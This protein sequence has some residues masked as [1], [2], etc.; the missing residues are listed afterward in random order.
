MAIQAIVG[1]VG[2]AI[3]KMIDAEG[4]PTPKYDDVRGVA[5]TSTV[6][7]AAAVTDQDDIPMDAEIAFLRATLPDEML[8]LGASFDGDPS[9]GER[10]INVAT[11]VIEIREP[12]PGEAFAA[13]IEIEFVPV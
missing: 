4:R 10:S 9:E 3:L 11:D 13:T 7:D 12:E 2:K 6:P 1:Q 5:W 8:T